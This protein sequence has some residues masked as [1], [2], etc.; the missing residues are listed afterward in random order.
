MAYFVATFAPLDESEAV[1]NGN[2]STSIQA[3]DFSAALIAALTLEVKFESIGY[4]LE[5]LLLDC[6]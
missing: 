3:G 5:Q 1:F 2:V 4:R 6:D